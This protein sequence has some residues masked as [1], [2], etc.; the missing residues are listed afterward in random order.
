MFDQFAA[1]AE[2]VGSEVH[3]LDT[4]PA[5]REFIL[6][7]LGPLGVADRPGDLALWAGGAPAGESDR[8][9]MVDRAPGLRFEVSRDLAA[10]ARVGV[11]AMDWALADT[12]TLAQDQTAVEQRLVSTLPRVHIA[13]VHTG[14]VLPDLAALIEKVGPAWPPFLALITGPSRTADIERVLTIG[15]HGPSRLIIVGV[16]EALDSPG[17]GQ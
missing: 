3:R 11:S 1:R 2:A 9:R 13:L 14:C 6:S 5:A 15:V 17:D 12:G 7:L 10:S 16:N 8:G 4:M